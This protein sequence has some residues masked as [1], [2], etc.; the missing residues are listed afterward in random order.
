MRGTR[1]ISK[2]KLMNWKRRLLWKLYSSLKTCYE[3]DNQFKQ[4]EPFFWDHLSNKSPEVI[5]GIISNI[6]YKVKKEK[7]FLQ[8][9]ETNT[10]TYFTFVIYAETNEILELTAGVQ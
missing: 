5:S 2:E 10:Y 9:N 3:S 6:G 7:K 1:C 4:R 8:P